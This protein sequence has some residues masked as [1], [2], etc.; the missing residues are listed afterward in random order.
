VLSS[1]LWL[2]L[3][4]FFPSLINRADYLIKFHRTTDK[5]F[6]LGSK[7]MNGS[8]FKLPVKRSL[9]TSFW[10]LL[11]GSLVIGGVVGLCCF[12][13]SHLLS[14]LNLGVDHAKK[15]G[16][17]HED[18]SRLGG[19]AIALTFLLVVI[20]EALWSGTGSAFDDY[21]DLVALVSVTLPIAFIGFVD[22]ISQR[23]SSSV[24]LVFMALFAIIG[25]ISFP[26]L[27]PTG[28]LQEFF[29]SEN[30]FG[31]LVFSVFF[32]VG[33]INA[34]NMVDGANGLLSI[35]VASFFGFCFYLTKTN[36]H[37]LMMLV[38]SV[39][40]FINLF[41]GTKIMLGDFGAFGLSALTILTAFSVYQIYNVSIFL[42]ASLLCYPCIEIVRIFT[43]RLWIGESP[44]T[45][46]NQHGHNLLF[47]GLSRLF[48][49][50]VANSL[51]GVVIA[52]ISVVPAWVLLAL[53]WS[54][55]TDLFLVVFL[56]QSLIYIAGTAL[57][58]RFF[59]GL[60]KS[61]EGSQGM[62]P[63]LQEP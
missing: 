56:F 62:R 49:P 20:F 39:F 53:G 40:A 50:K 60:Y 46:D 18:G 10:W 26:Q 38:V 22:D 51:T 33:F 43:A 14:R 52:L 31:L 63:R 34:G 44:L 6:E 7:S 48:N 32:F 36:A 16:I 58:K 9:G 28:I 41:G 4:R 17:S 5:A 1:S 21:G 45:A 61:G 59:G 57:L 24:R 15:H 30:R 27:M 37:Y 55:Q 2:L 25:F 54:Y 47:A 23:L 12:V 3:Q 11:G 42:Y 8:F 19:V 29:G 13:L 35:L